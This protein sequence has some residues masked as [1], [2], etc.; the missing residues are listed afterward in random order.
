MKMVNPRVGPKNGVDASA[1][2]VIVTLAYTITRCALPGMK[3]SSIVST[4]VPAVEGQDRH[5]VEQPDD[6]PRPP[7]RLTRR[8]LD[9]GRV[10]ER[11]GPHR[12]Q[13][14]APADD[15]GQWA[16]QRDADRPR[17]ADRRASTRTT[18]SRP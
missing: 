15:V 5:E 7:H 18:C 12:H 8:G 16:G 1:A 9:D 2:S 10:V 4:D 6:R 11:V 3:R 17:P 13:H 14:E